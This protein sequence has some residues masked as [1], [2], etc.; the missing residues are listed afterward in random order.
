MRVGN[1]H[2]AFE[3]AGLVHPGGAGHLAVAVER[4]PAGERRVA[5]ALAAR[6]NRRDA[7]AGGAVREG[8]ETDFDALHVGNS[9]QRARRAVK[10]NS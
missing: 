7:G 6:Q 5:R 3:E 1:H 2:R 9:V 10:R 8:D 4:E